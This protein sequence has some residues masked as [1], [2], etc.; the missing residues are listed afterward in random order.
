MHACA[1]DMEHNYIM[2]DSLL[3]NVQIACAMKT[4]LRVNKNIEWAK[5]CEFFCGNDVMT[6]ISVVPRQETLF[7]S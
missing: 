1:V 2:I 3:Q 5:Y 6:L 7:A 4:R